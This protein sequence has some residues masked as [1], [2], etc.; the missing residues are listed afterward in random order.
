MSGELTLVAVIGVGLI[1][2]MMAVLL[3]QYKPEFALLT[4]LAASI[5]IFTMMV[6]WVMPAID[7]V[8]EL[9]DQSPTLSESATTLLKA[10]GICFLT[11]LACDLCKD[12]GENTIATRVETAGKA[13]I[14]LV[15]LPLFEQVL[16]L[17]LALL[18]A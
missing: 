1:G 13:A 8:R 4:V 10:V 6:K 5:L 15:S 12:A 11:Q 14:L 7:K 9:L 17:V 3:R 2:A 16:S 18:N